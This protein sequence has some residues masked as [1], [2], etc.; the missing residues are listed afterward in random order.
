MKNTAILIVALLLSV[1]AF[2]QTDTTAVAEDSSW[3]AKEKAKQDS[4]TYVRNYLNN[5]YYN[6][7]YNKNTYSY[8]ERYE[9]ERYLVLGAG[10][11][12]YY[13]KA[14]DSIGMFHGL[15]TEIVFY[16][17]AVLASGGPGRFKLYGRFNWYHSSKKEMGNMFNYAFGANFSFEK[18]PKR[19]FLIPFFGVEIGGIHH[20]EGGD[21][22]QI[23]P[24]LGVRL[25]DSKNFSLTIDGGYS[26]AVPHFDV[27]AGIQ[28]NIGISVFFW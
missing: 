27:L 15:S 7:Y 18:A 1:T 25:F 12:F 11:T 2:A 5:S 16:E 9:W 24:Y 8:D 10:Y 22:F 13:P 4:I 14:V 19:K 21:A 6:N 23:K 20:R 26:Y 3:T 28:A 17:Q